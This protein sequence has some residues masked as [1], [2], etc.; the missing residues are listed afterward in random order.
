MK[1]LTGPAAKS[2]SRRAL[3]MLAAGGAR[4]GRA[5][6]D[7]RPA[8]DRR[9]SRRRRSIGA[10][11]EAPQQSQQFAFV[12]RK[13]ASVVTNLFGGHSW[14]V[15]PP[16][17]PPVVYGTAPPSAPPLPSRCSAATRRRVVRRCTSW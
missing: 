3:M 16:P 14:Y 7:G 5:V 4:D 1:L 13:V 9:R 11:G 10:R 17:P 15:A 6:G 12:P 8:G 2:G